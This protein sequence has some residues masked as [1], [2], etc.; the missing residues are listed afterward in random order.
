L[1]LRGINFAR[2][3]NCDDGVFFDDNPVSNI[4][5]EGLVLQCGGD[6]IDARFGRGPRERV[7]VQDNVIR[8]SDEPGQGSTGIVVADGRNWRIARNIIFSAPVADASAVELLGGADATVINNLLVGSIGVRLSFDA[9]AGAPPTNHQILLNRIEALQT[10]IRLDDGATGN[11]VL[12]NRICLY[13]SA[14]PAIFLGPDTS[15][16]RVRRNQAA[17]VRGGNFVVVEDLGTANDKA[18]NTRRG[19]CRS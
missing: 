13:R 18:N 2:I 19:R 12:D 16:N 14:G 7:T 11:R 6:G 3:V 5:I 8:S 9:V 10:G 17:L 1:T 15:D 4:L